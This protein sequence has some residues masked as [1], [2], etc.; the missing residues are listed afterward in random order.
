MKDRYSK[1]EDW[2]DVRNDCLTQPRPVLASHHSSYDDLLSSETVTDTG[3]RTAMKYERPGK[4]VEK[5]ELRTFLAE[6]F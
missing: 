2:D 1:F 4:E 3:N 6:D 5:V